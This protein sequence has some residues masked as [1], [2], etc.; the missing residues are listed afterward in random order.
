MQYS[1]PTANPIQNALVYGW[2]EPN[3]CS[4]FD[5]GAPLDAPVAGVQY[6]SEHVLEW[7]LIALFFRELDNNEPF[8]LDPDPRSKS[9]MKFCNYVKKYWSVDIAVNGGTPKNP[10]Q[11]IADQ[12]PTVDTFT[13]EFVL[14]E[15]DIN[16]PSK[17]K[18]SPR[19]LR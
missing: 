10:A 7:Q 14:L 6:D 1:L 13:D 2:E 11:H 4:S 5:F 12:Y 18:V 8:V 16:T 3:V 9:E 17:G 15:H 19:I